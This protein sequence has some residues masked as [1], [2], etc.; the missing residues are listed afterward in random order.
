MNV[1]LDD[2][3]PKC[4]GIVTSKSAYIKSG[5]WEKLTKMFDARNIRHLMYNKVSTNP[6]IDM[7]GECV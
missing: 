3:K 7:V 5:V 1:I 6:T 4:V 2:L